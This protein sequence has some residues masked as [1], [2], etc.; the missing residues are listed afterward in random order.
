[1]IADMH[2]SGI[3]LDTIIVAVRSMELALS[4]R[5]QVDVVAENRRAW[6]REYRRERR[7]RPPDSTRHPP[8]PPDIANSALSYLRK[9]DSYSEEVIKKERKEKKERGH[10][11]PPDWKPKPL[12]YEAGEKLGMNRAA[13]DERAVAMR[14]WCDAN[15]NRSITTKANWDAAFMGAWLKDSRNGNG[16]NGIRTHQAT[17]PAPTRDATF[18]AAMGRT[19]ERRRAARAADDAGRNDVRE[20]GCSGAANG[21]DADSAA[22][23]GDDDP[24]GHPALILAGYVRG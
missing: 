21:A 18:I 9:E 13:V 1:M 16:T 11:L 2:A 14:T 6:D 15:A 7:K 8:D 19:L 20:A 10:K 22:E 23:G 12:H 3:Q 4:T 24:P 5:R 17:G